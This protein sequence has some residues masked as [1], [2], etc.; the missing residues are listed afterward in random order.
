MPN[1]TKTP[2]PP[3]QRGK[4]G[5][6]V[7]KT[8]T[9]S[10]PTKVPTSVP[11]TT[12]R[13]TSVGNP[14]YGPAPTQR[15]PVVG[16]TQ[17]APVGPR[18]GGPAVGYQAPSYPVQLFMD[19]L[20]YLM[21]GTAG[22]AGS[23]LGSLIGPWGTV[24]GAGLFGSAGYGAGVGIQNSFQGAVNNQNYGGPPV[25]NTTSQR[26]NEFNNAMW[27]IGDPS[28]QGPENTA[29][30]D[31]YLLTHPRPDFDQRPP[32]GVRVTNG[33][34][35]R[36]AAEV[37]DAAPP[38]GGGALTY[39]QMMELMLANQP[40]IDP[41]PLGS[42]GNPY[43]Y[44]YPPGF[45][46]NAPPNTNTGDAQSEFEKLAMLMQIGKFA[47]TPPPVDNTQRD[48]LFALLQQSQEK[49]QALTADFQGLL[50][51]ML[52]QMQ[53]GAAIPAAALPA[54]P[55]GATGNSFPLTNIPSISNMGSNLQLSNAG[56]GYL[57]DINPA[58]NRILQQMLAA[59]KYTDTGQAGQYGPL[60][61]A[62]AGGYGSLAFNDADYE[63]PLN[64]A[65]VQPADRES[66]E[67]A[68]RMM[69]SKMGLNA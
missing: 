42:A 69:I 32:P 68:L 41:N 35:V 36:P 52:T 44:A 7:T 67:A 45:D 27:N 18:P 19:S 58:L 46:P 21:A 8:A 33:P 53:S 49:I 26:D 20:P 11:I 2:P 13:A 38:I 5:P 47:P 60:N 25:V 40:A 6:I 3:N 23:V 66:S 28:R 63:N 14:Q 24:G 56:L 43:Q 17:R 62:R 15:A 61:Y 10:A 16:P 54:A 55:A 34:P 4:Q 22:T 1:P 57:N 37:P 29:A 12:Q 9:Q 39:A 51:K 64:Y 65:G 30:L 31:Q 50:L 59:K 48:Q